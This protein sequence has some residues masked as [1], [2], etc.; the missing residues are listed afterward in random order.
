MGWSDL[1]EHARARR[2]RVPTLTVLV[3]SREIGTKLWEGWASGRATATISSDSPRAAITTWLSRLPYESWRLAAAA[4]LGSSTSNSQV[5]TGPDCLERRILLDRLVGSEGDAGLGAAC[6]ALVEGIGTSGTWDGLDERVA[7]KEPDPPWLRLVRPLARVAGETAPTLLFL[8]FVGRLAATLETAGNIVVRAP[9]LPVCAVVE[10]ADH[11]RYLRDAPETRWKA[12]V[13]EG[14]IRPGSQ[15]RT[16]TAP[17]PA[18][19]PPPP[20]EA[21]SAAEQFLFERLEEQPA[22]RG[23]FLL[24]EDLDGMEIDLLS[25]AR[26]VAVEIDGFHHFNDPAAFRRDRRKDVTLQKLGYLVVRVLAD[27]V[28]ERLEEVLRDINRALADR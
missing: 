18:F 22:T 10:G 16:R 19:I 20:S 1:E 26:K 27:D 6:R 2:A 14:S 21:R 7:G 25:P 9:L 5:L 11:E 13:R 17:M 4:R 15:P 12:L 23:L 28:T 3:A 8:P 24:N